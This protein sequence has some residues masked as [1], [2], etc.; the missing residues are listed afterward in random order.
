MQQPRSSTAKDREIG[1]ILL[2]PDQPACRDIRRPAMTA[3]E[4]ESYELFRCAIVLRDADAWAAIY[5]RYR[6]LLIAWAYRSIARTGIAECADDIADQALV[7]AWVALKPERFAAFLTLAKLLAYLRAC[8]TTTTIDIARA[9]ATS[10]DPLS[11]GSTLAT[12]E[13]L[14]LADLDRTALWRTAL[15]LAATDAERILLV[16]SFA[17]GLPPRAIQARHPEIFANAAAVYAAK[18]N[19]FDRLR[20]H[21]EL[22]RLREELG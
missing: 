4:M 7:R 8:V 14:V 20:R 18:R 12:P 17:N 10:A 21:P 13:Q 19:L 2:L 6:P 3:P 1:A 22:R 15:G 9:Q 16:E 5:A 11:S